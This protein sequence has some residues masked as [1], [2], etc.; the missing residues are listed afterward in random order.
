MLI[1]PIPSMYGQSEAWHAVQEIVRGIGGKPRHS[2][3]FVE[4]LMQVLA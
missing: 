2:T 1:I 4:C 3:V